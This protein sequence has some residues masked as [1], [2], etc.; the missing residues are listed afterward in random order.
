MAARTVPAAAQTAAPRPPLEGLVALLTLVTLELVRSSGPLVDTAFG[1]DGTAGAVRFAVVG[2]GGA[3]LVALLLLAGVRRLVRRASAALLLG[4]V[5]LAGLRL[6][7]QGLTAGARVGLGLV[8]VAVAV[9][10]LT[11]AVAVLAGRRQGGRRAAAALVTGAAAAVG[12]QLA[13]GTWDAYWR[14]TPLGW[15]V[16]ALCSAGLVLLGVLTGRDRGTTPVLAARRLW[17]VGLWLAL[18]AAMLA[19]PAFAAAQSGLPLALAGP[20]LAV[21]LFVVAAPLTRS[22]SRGRADAAHPGPPHGV[23]AL[24]VVALALPA[25]VALA[26]TL[27][28][29]SAGGVVTVRAA[30]LG[31]LVLGALLAAQLAAARLVARALEPAAAGGRT[32]AV[33]YRTAGA[34]SVVGLTTIGPLLVTQLDYEVPLGFPNLLV[35]VATAATLALAGVRRPAPVPPTP[36][37]M[38][39]AELGAGADGRPAGPA[40][41][42]A[43]LLVLLGAAT[44][45]WS[46][47]SG[48]AADPADASGRVLTWNLHYGVSPTGSVDLEVV[49]RTIEAEDPDVVL[50]QEV[51]RGW[52]QGGGVDMATWLSQ[53]LGRDYAFAPAA[54]RRFGNVVLARAGLEDVHVQP[55]PYGVGPQQRS[56]L[57]AT[58]RLGG[59]AVRVTSLHLQHRSGAAG[60]RVAEVETFLAAP[61]G[62]VPDGLPQVLGGDLNAAPGEPPPVLV[63]RAGFVSAVDTAGDPDARTSPSARPVRRI[64]WIFGRDLAF[65]HARVIGGVELSDHLP[66]V[67]EVR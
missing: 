16:A 45:V 4:S 62:G 19:N 50:L 55:L 48:S 38:E 49:A 39:A 44:A 52:V 5:L 58:T 29:G 51:S 54:D 61:G 22:R 63:V 40:R 37:P 10:V 1:R 9:A 59:R 42:G 17:T 53:R 57:S 60:T 34:A 12:L 23:P 33:P 6:V 24:V 26:L 65:T 31:S 43:A 13:L 20:L 47:T 18:A 28:A 27:P 8:A 36:A 41:L 32:A 11:L 46:A 21:G 30:V 64:D 3:G 25:G 66:V 56:A 7:V 15:A 35:L 2:Y 67:A 14:H